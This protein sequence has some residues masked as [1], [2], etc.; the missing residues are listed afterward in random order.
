[1]SRN[2]VAQVLD[3]NTEMIYD[4]SQQRRLIGARQRGPKVLSPLEC[5]VWAE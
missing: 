1:M 5:W 2:E 3:K 4:Q